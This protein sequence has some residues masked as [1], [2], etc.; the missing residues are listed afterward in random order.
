MVEEDFIVQIRN[1]EN[2]ADTMLDAA[3]EQSRISLEGARQKAADMIASA[4]NQAEISFNSALA[5]AQEQVIQIESNISSNIII[6]INNT[7][8]DA[9]ANA[10]AERIVK[11]CVNL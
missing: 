3:R 4:H 5:D 7:E 9:A 6:D 11:N 10:V 1:I 8:I 2:Q